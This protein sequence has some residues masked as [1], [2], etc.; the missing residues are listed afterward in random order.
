[1]SENTTEAVQDN[2]QEVATQSQEEVTET[3]NVGGLIQ[4]SKKNRKRN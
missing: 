2:V 1:M 4:E 3:P